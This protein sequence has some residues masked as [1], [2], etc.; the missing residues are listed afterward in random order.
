[1]RIVQIEH[2]LR[3]TAPAMKRDPGA[4]TD[5]GA[6][7]SSW[8]GAL[9]LPR[10]SLSSRDGLCHSRSLD[11]LAYERSR[12]RRMEDRIDPNGTRGIPRNRTQRR[13]GFRRDG[14]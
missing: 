13:C 6:A 14:E 5:S 2:A 12:F 1:M 3:L 8:Y 9:E 4:P 7:G 11:P 10:G